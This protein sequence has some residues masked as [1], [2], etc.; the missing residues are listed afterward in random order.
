MITLKAVSL[1]GLTKIVPYQLADIAFKAVLDK[2]VREE[3]VYAWR[4]FL[5]RLF[6]K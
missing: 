4:P 6:A 5:L 1:N 2:S 3:H